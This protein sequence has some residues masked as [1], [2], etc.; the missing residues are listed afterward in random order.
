MNAN[1]KDLS[2]GLVF[3]AIAAMFAIGT[4]ELDLGTPRALGPGA[5]PLLISGVL[6]LLGLIITVRAFSG[7]PERI[8]NLPWRAI[9]LVV[10]APVVFALTIRGLGLV[11]AIALVVAIGAYASQRMSARL[12]ASLIVGLTAFCVLVFNVGLGL[13]IRLVGTWLRGLGG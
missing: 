4:L 1:A 6:G 10:V 13:P 7:A 12:A 8:A 3:I 2:A 9:I 5:F 11:V